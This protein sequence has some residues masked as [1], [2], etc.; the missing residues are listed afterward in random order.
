MTGDALPLTRQEAG[1]YLTRKRGVPTSAK[2]LSK[3]ATLSGGPRYRRFGRITRYDVADLDA[4]ADSKI[5]E[6][7]RS[8]SSR[9]VRDAVNPIASERQV[10]LED[11]TSRP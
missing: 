7:R 1:Q 4:Y 5:S 11:L 10:D 9:T 3:L 8:T 2:T 6:P